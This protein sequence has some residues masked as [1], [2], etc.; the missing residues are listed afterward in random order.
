MKVFVS[1][2]IT[3]FEEYRRAA[4]CAIRT[5]G[6]DV[7]RAEDFGASADS[8][9]QVCLQGVGQAPVVVLLLGAR[10]GTPGPS[11][12]SP[13][14]EEFREARDRCRVL[15]F[16]QRGVEPDPNQKVFIKEARDWASGTLTADLP[17][18]WSPRRSS[19]PTT[20]SGGRGRSR[21]AVEISGRRVTGRTSS[22]SGLTRPAA[23]APR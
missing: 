4:A 22:R 15:V 18:S 16:V 23:S 20:A 12:L 11:G 3:G 7:I 5:L 21:S 1:S 19:A 2:V 13:T 6:H 9:Q 8:P 10:Y 14:H 17:T